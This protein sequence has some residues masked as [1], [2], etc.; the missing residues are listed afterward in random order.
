MHTVYGWLSEKQSRPV[1]SGLEG[2]TCL[3]VVTEETKVLLAHCR[4]KR[5]SGRVCHFKAAYSL[6]LKR[7]ENTSGKTMQHMQFNV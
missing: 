5:G 4:A 3:Q 1:V 2:N 7:T 6:K